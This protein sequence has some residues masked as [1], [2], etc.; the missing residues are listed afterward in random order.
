MTRATLSPTHNP[1]NTG[2]RGATRGGIGTLDFDAVDPQ[3]GVSVN[4][5]RAEVDDA[6]KDMQ[7]FHQMEPD[8]IMR[9]AGGHS[10]R[11]SYL[12]VCALRIEDFKREWKDVR[13]RELEPTLEQLEHQFSIAS[14]LHSVRELD[15]KME[16]GER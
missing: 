12:R 16:A 8:E 6:Y 3:I 11:L 15:W 10:A 13:T 2:S 9:R 4:Q 1:G 14:R 5:V 7:M